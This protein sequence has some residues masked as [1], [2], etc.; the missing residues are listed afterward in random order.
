MNVDITQQLIQLALQA[1]I[2]A[3]VLLFLY[4]NNQNWQSFLKERNQKTE[5]A[6]AEMSD[7]AQES[8]ERVA[9][10]LMELTRQLAENTKTQA[11]TGEILARVRERVGD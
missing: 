8:R 5:K 6:L 10:A 2:L 9:T 4:K 11:R 1:P 3:L 7:R